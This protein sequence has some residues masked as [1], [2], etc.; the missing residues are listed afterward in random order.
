MI[1]SLIETKPI[2][3]STPGGGGTV[4]TAIG[5]K[6]IIGTLFQTNNLGPGDLLWYLDDA[7][8]QQMLVI[9][10]VASEISATVKTAPLTVTTANDYDISE[11]LSDVSSGYVI[12][13]NAN[14]KAMIASGGFNAMFLRSP[15]N[16]KTLFS[17]DEGVLLKTIYMRLPYQF[18][19]ASSPIS[20]LFTYR[21]FDGSLL[22]IITA[23]GEANLAGTATDGLFIPVENSE[24]DVNVYIQPPTNSPAGGWGIGIQIDETGD[25]D[26]GIEVTDAQASISMVSAPDTFNGKLL[27]VIIGARILHAN[28]SMV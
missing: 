2:T 3:N 13:N 8:K 10:T 12:A 27:P 19:M 9:N 22:G 7:G 17:R 4:T 1:E 16:F 14:D 20:L 24:I 18:T 26:D 21:Q 28:I 6:T 11:V 25:L 15:K 5:N 23:I